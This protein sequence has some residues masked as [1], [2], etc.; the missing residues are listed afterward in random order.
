[1]VELVHIDHSPESLK[2]EFGLTAPTIR[3]L[4][5]QSTGR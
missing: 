1:M 4:R 5:A 2:K 3:K